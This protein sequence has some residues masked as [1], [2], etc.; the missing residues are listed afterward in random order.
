LGCELLEIEAMV[1]SM[2]KQGCTDQEIAD[3]LEVHPAA[4]RLLIEKI[5]EKI[6]QQQFQ[7]MGSSG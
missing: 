6:Q 7:V 5:H 3:L 1:W 4:V 2:T